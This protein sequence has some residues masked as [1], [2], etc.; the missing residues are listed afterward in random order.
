MVIV[1][2]PFLLAVAT[3]V[4]LLAW[5]DWEPVG[6]GVSHLTRTAAE[7]VGVVTPLQL[8]HQPPDRPVAEVMTREITAASAELSL[9]HAHTLFTRQRLAIERSTTNPP[10]AMPKYTT[11]TPM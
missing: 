7:V 4:Y 6:T 8:L 5:L 3:S 9:F 10:T 1:M 11:R 2:L